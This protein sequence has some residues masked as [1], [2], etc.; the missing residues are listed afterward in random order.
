MKTITNYEGG[1][2]AGRWTPNHH[3]QQHDLDLPED[4][5]RS[6]RSR[7]GSHEFIG[8]GANTDSIEDLIAEYTKWK[9][10]RRPM[11]YEAWLRD[12]K[13]SDSKDASSRYN[14][15]SRV[16]IMDAPPPELMRE[17]LKW[18]RQNGHG[19]P[20]KEM[21]DPFVR[22]SKER[23]DIMTAPSAE[24]I[25]NYEKWK[26]NAHDP[27]PNDVERHMKWF[28]LKYILNQFES[29]GRGPSG[30]GGPPGRGYGGPG[31]GYR[32]PDYASL[33]DRY[34][35]GYGG[36]PGGPLG[37]GYHGGPP[38]GPGPRDYIGPDG[39]YYNGPGYPPNPRE[40]TGGP[41]GGYYG[42][43]PPPG[44]GGMYE[45]PGNPYDSPG[46]RGGFSRGGGGPTRGR[47]RDQGRRPPGPSSM[48]KLINFFGV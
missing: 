40:Y 27:I 3:G 7:L 38:G 26:N 13:L 6:L 17:Y 18:V 16:W 39:S 22:W 1:G 45:E 24:T 21:I 2:D 43:P 30:G 31:P 19:P 46:R 32:G 20:P 34:Y 35:E 37:G 33:G 11:S 42:G 47:G 9:N 41:G 15:W 29:G 12:Q 36:P 48:S 23:F 8:N 5:P 14:E 10:D 25:A 28:K 44:P 4:M